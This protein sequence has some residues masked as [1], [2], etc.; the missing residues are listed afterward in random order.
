MRH[1]F[2][3]WLFRKLL[4]LLGLACACHANDTVNQLFRDGQRAEHLGDQV[5]AYVLYARAAALDPTNSKILARKDALAALLAGAAETSL[6]ADPAADADIDAQLADDTGG[7]QVTEEFLPG[8]IERDREAPPPPRLQAPPGT[9]HFALRGTG[10]SVCEQVA[11]AYGIQLVF[12]HDY[13]DT[14]PFNFHTGEM[15]MAEALRTLE[16]MTNS[17]IMPLNERLALVVRDTAQ[18][19]SD[20]TAVMFASIPIPERISVQD[21]QEMVTAVQQTLQIKTLSMD[22]GRHMVFLRDS[23]GKVIA[24]RQIFADLS[25]LRAQVEVDVQLLSVTK[26]S[27]LGIGLT[28]P[29]ASTIVNFGNFLQNAVSPAGFSQFLSFGGG[30]T[31]FGLGVASAQAFATLARSSTDTV[32]SS[33]VMTLDGQPATLHVGE[34]YPVITN[35]YIG[36]TTGTTGQVFAPPPTVNFEDL[37][38]TLKITPSVHAG[39]EMTLDIDAAYT[40]LGNLNAAGIPT[41]SQRKYQGKVRVNSDEWVVIAGLT[42]ETD[43][44]SISGI[45]GLARIPGAG[46]LFRND[47]YATDTT[48]TLIV[49]KPRMV[50]LPPWETPTHMVWVGTESKPIDSY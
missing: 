14:P 16:A 29:N 3:D 42:Q 11:R 41:I 10:Q 25:R 4:I 23:V 45:A 18:R 44:H 50:N 20:T 28:L 26:D 36:T 37:G 6:D 49:L 31:L 33:Q 19:R 32:F 34:R 43:S 15:T 2:L 17:I 9:Q 7:A 22:P 1:P 12:E 47:N 30:K 38:L 39:G 21:A 35:T 8:E 13:Q 48:E 5:H 40:V 27:S 24:A 46:R